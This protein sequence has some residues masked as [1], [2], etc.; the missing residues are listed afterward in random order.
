V[1]LFE[2]H[3]ELEVRVHTATP[4]LYVLVGLFI[5]AFLS[6]NFVSNDDSG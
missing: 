2:L 1:E 6:E 3:N 5:G 4:A